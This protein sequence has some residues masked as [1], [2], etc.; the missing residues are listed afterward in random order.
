MRNHFY[1]LKKICPAIKNNVELTNEIKEYIL[2][3]RIPEPEQIINTNSNNTN[4]NTNTNT[5]TNS[6]NNT[7]TNTDT[8]N[9]TND[10]DNNNDT[11]TNNTNTNTNSELNIITNF[12]IKKYKSRYNINEVVYK[13]EM[14]K[15]PDKYISKIDSKLLYNG[16]YYITKSKLIEVLEKSLSAKAKQFLNQLK[17]EKNSKTT[18]IKQQVVVNSYLQKENEISDTRSELVVSNS[19]NVIDYNQNLLYFNKKTIKY[20]YY[21]DTIYFKG[22]EVADILGYSD[23]DQAI[24]MHIDK[25]D[26]IETSFFNPVNLTGFD[27]MNEH[28]KI[29][30]IIK[31]E[32][33][34][35]IFINESGFY[36]LVCTSKMPEAKKFKKW[37]TSEVLPSIRKTG[38]YSIN[39]YNNLEKYNGKDCIYILH[40]KDNIYKFGKSSELKDRLNNH[41]NNL[42]YIQIIKIYICEN[43]NKMKEVEDSIKKLVKDYKINIIY[44]NHI[45]IFN[46]TNEI[47]I[48]KVINEINKIFDTINNLSIDDIKNNI[49]IEKISLLEAN[50]DYFNKSKLLELKNISI[51]EKTK[52]ME[53][54]KCIK[55]EEEKTKQLELQI[56]FFKL[57]GKII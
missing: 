43:M 40:I 53:I 17:E 18:V 50:L 12:N 33:P 41:K 24:R 34:Q 16:E 47:T 20:F 22:K 11:N 46:T 29:Q 28:A 23:Y 13:C 9:N 27:K 21:N 38:F 14:S 55:L 56:E 10:N 52:Q 36:S 30:A 51:I 4:I 48:N 42:N 2:N 19:I 15:Y 26:K 25:E 35:T 37:V 39:N 6:N 45:E 49:L 54:E 1:N 3:N 7:N 5:N 8:N 31:N 44:E 57:T 32:H